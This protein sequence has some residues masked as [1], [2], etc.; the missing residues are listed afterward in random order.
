M[1]LIL[2]N[3]FHL[4]RASQKLREKKISNCSLLYLTI[5]LRGEG[6]RKMVE[7]IEGGNKFLLR[8]VAVTEYVAVDLSKK[9]LCACVRNY[10]VSDCLVKK[11]WSR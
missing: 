1:R 3:Y 2:L 5:P 10:G 9:M 4:L 6:G 7:M 11:V 8:A